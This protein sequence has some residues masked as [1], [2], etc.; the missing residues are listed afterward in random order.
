MSLQLL[1]DI[2][3]PLN[4]CRSIHGRFYDL[5]IHKVVPL[6]LCQVFKVFLQPYVMLDQKELHS[7][8]M[9]DELLHAE[10]AIA[11]WLVPNITIL[12]QTL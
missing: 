6:A 8:C 2:D 11:L 7:P 9:K 12:N 10:R 5:F 1:Q 4:A 3:V